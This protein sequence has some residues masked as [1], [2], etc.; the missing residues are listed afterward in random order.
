MIQGIQGQLY[1]N[2]M[3][4]STAI[5]S[6]LYGFKEQNINITVKDLETVILAIEL[7]ISI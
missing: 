1:I 3:A 6:I 4:H 2:T 7:S 5:Y